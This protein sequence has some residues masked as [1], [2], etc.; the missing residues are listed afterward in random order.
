[1]PWDGVEKNPE[2]DL[3]YC[4]H[5]SNIF[6][7][8]HRPYLALVEV[9]SNKL[10]DGDETDVEKE[11]I[12]ANARE[13]ISEFPEGSFKKRMMNALQAFRL[14]Y[15]DAAAVPPNGEGSYPWCVQRRTIVIELPGGDSTVRSTIPNPLYSYSFHPVPVEDFRSVA[16]GQP[17]PWIEW[18]CTKRLPTTKTTDA[19]SQ[20]KE[21]AFHLDWNQV[22]MRQRTYQMLAMQKDYYSISNNAVQTKDPN[23]GVVLDSLESVHDTLHNT[24]GDGG[25][26][27]QTQYSSFD[28]TFWLLHTYVSQPSLLFGGLTKNSNTDRLLAIWQALNPNSYVTNHSNPLATFT[29]PARAWADE[30][31]RECG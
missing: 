10:I 24:I 14:P 5:S 26:M 16:A 19:E 7:P 13:V 28:P 22:N 27:W 11:R 8:W 15:W 30:N 1:M 21:V 4:R 18:N 29:T 12:Y 6:A 3:G 20:D 25:H 2:G 31:T 9:A 23:S 17:D